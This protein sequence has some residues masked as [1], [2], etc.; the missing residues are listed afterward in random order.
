VRARGA[1]SAWCRTRGPAAVFAAEGRALIVYRCHGLRPT[2]AR[3]THPPL[4]SLRPAL[5][6]PLAFAAPWAVR[7]GS[8]DLADTRS[9]AKTGLRG[10]GR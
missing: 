8:I 1:R 3:L 7:M 5:A 10:I 2:E 4:G 9:T 6:R